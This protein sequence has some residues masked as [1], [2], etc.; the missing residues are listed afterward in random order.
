MRKRIKVELAV[1][2]QSIYSVVPVNGGM[3][4]AKM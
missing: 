1:E 4:S 2:I 3:N